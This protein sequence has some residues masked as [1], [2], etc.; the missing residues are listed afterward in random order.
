MIDDLD[1]FLMIIWK[2]TS[3]DRTI[4]DGGVPRLL[5]TRILS[6]TAKSIRDKI[7]FRGTYHHLPYHVGY[8]NG[9]QNQ[10]FLMKHVI[11]KLALFCE[12]KAIKRFQGLETYAKHVNSIQIWLN[13]LFWAGAVQTVHLH[14]GFVMVCIP[15]VVDDLPTAGVGR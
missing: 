2:F 10:Q 4:L 9:W 6:Q 1:C 15:N 14:E 3:D 7:S 11:A 5:R 13:V 12:H 8:N